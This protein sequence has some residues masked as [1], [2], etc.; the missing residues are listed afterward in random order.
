MYG[1]STRTGKRISCT[2]L[3]KLLAQW[4]FVDKP[5]TARD[6]QRGRGPRNV[7]DETYGRQ[8]EVYVG[9]GTRE[10]RAEL[11]RLCRRHDI[12]VDPEWAEGSCSLNIGVTYFRGWHWDE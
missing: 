1:Y 6:L 3:G 2:K 11:L 7:S 5:F 9:C 4:G 12:N 10:R 8:S